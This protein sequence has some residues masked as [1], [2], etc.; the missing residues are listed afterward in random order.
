MWAP[1]VMKEADDD[2]TDLFATPSAAD[3]EASGSDEGE[4][5]EGDPAVGRGARGGRGALRG[6]PRR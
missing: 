3:D 4:G 6:L 5:A 2:Q 1:A